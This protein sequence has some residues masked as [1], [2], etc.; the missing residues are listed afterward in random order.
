MKKKSFYLALCLSMYVAAVAVMSI[1]ID[2][3]MMSK[4]IPSYLLFMGVTF[5]MIGYVSIIQYDRISNQ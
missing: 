4:E 1:C 5:V 2:K 3:A